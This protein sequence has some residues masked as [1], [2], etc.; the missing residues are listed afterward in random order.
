MFLYIAVIKSYYKHILTEL[1]TN[2]L[3]LFSQDS[4]ATIW[5]IG[6]SGPNQGLGIFLLTTMSTLTLG[7]SQPPILWVPGAL[8]LWI[9]LPGCEADHSSPSS[10]DGAVPPLQYAFMARCSVK[11]MNN[12]I[13]IKAMIK[14]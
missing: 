8:S 7:P 2:L 10:A 14:L 9:K 1:R 3:L 5:M 6:G 13:L 11:S 4:W 12:F